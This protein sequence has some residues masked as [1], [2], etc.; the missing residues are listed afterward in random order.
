[1]HEGKSEIKHKLILSNRNELL[2]SRVMQRVWSSSGYDYRK[3]NTDCD[4]D[5]KKLSGGSGTSD[6]NSTGL[7]W[8]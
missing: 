3:L 2:Y 8:K 6:D 1:M 4:A 7:K 5:L